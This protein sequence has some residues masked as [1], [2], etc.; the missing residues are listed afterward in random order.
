MFKNNPEENSKACGKGEDKTSKGSSAKQI[1]VAKVFYGSKRL[2]DCM[3]F[4]IRIHKAD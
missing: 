4:I 1:R 2:T 3:E